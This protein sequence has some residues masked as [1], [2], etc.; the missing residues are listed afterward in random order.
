TFPFFDEGFVS[1]KENKLPLYK[2]MFHPRVAGLY[3][4][5]LI[6]PLGAIMPIAERQSQLIARHLT[7]AYALPSQSEMESDIE[8]KLAAMR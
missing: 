3:F 5:G 7:G 8:K 2:F 1:V 6:Q 4:L